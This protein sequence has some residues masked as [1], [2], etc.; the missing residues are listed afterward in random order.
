MGWARQGMIG[1]GRAWEG[2]LGH[3]TVGRKRD[4]GRSCSS[5]GPA[6]LRPFPALQRPVQARLPAGGGCPALRRALHLRLLA[7]HAERGAGPGFSG[8]PRN[9]LKDTFGDVAGAWI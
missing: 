1:S 5:P 7:E 9:L 3:G 4:Q 6:P 8:L 2:M